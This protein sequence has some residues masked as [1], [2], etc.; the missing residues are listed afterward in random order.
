MN[1]EELSILLQVKIQQIK[2]MMA[3]GYDVSTEENILSYNPQSP[4]HLRLFEEYYRGEDE[5]FI[6][7]HLSQ[8]YVKEKNKKKKEESKKKKDIVTYVFYI[9]KKTEGQSEEISFP[10]L[11]EPL[12]KVSYIIQNEPNIQIDSTI[13]ISKKGL[14]STTSTRLVSRMDN[15]I[16]LWQVFTYTDLLINPTDYYALDRVNDDEEPL[17]AFAYSKLTPDELERLTKEVNIQQLPIIKY[18]PIQSGVNKVFSDPVVKYYNY[19]PGDVIRVTRTVFYNNCFART[20]YV[21][22]QVAK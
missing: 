10:D 6:E 22:R 7:Q 21:Y 13:I 8:K 20:S 17:K 18:A 19:K 4:E 9:T 2:M 12:N 1:F 5:I 14:S 11:V 3:R 15:K 16:D